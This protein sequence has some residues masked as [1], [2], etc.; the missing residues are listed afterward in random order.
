MPLRPLTLLTLLLTFPLPAAP[1]TTQPTPDIESLIAQLTADRRP[2]RQR[3]QDRLVE[4]GSASPD[5][6]SRLRR[7]L[8]E[9]RDDEAASRAQAALRL[10]A[11]NKA[12]GPTAITLHLKDADAKTAFTALAKT[13]GID[14]GT[15]PPDL[16]AQKPA[17][18]VG[19]S[20]IT[21]DADSQPF[22]SVFRDLCRQARVEPDFGDNGRFKLLESTDGKWAAT[23]AVVAGPV[24]IRA[25]K[26]TETR[27]L[28]FADPANP[29]LSRQLEMNF[30]IE[31][32]LR[33]LADAFAARIES[34]IDDQGKSL[35]PAPPAAG[36]AAA[37]DQELT[38]VADTSRLW[39]LDVPLTCPANGGGRR[40]ASL[41]GS[42]R[43]KIPVKL[44]TLEIADV[45][46]APETPRAIAGRRLTFH[47]A[48]KVKGGYE[49]KVT[50]F[51]GALDDADWQQWATPRDFLRLVDA[52]GLPIL[53]T[54]V[55]DAQGNDQQTT[56]TL[57]FENPNNAPNGIGGPVGPPAR[58]LWDI[59][60][61]SKELRVPFEFKDLALP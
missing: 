60:I 17:G 50:L 61:D 41:K 10:I 21:L 43:L 9:T 47:S 7:L 15:E 55:S 18:G 22:W 45:L 2:D 25:V 29:E 16:W 37:D 36:E 26:I 20:P 42:V 27:A 6:E 39:E 28:E 44:Q 5:V 32:R 54:S 12:A 34:A 58:L 8:R 53:F 57:Q 38:N 3:A 4:L 23:P 35:M 1:P 14:I 24:L 11:E 49:V 13:S 30:Y 51:K 59:P 33:V 19:A 40:I 31:P 48:H 52:S 46:T 56:L